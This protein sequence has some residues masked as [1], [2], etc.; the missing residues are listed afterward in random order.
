MTTITY[1]I[2]DYAGA[3]GVDR[4]IT[5]DNR[6]VTGHLYRNMPT[7]TYTLPLHIPEIGITVLSIE[8]VEEAQSWQR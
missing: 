8:E 4:K 5:T 6:E 2:H 7:L 1:V 3:V